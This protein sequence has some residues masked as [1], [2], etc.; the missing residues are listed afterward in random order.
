MKYVTVTISKFCLTRIQTYKYILL[1]AVLS[2]F[3][4][5]FLSLLTGKLNLLYPDFQLCLPEITTALIWGHV[6]SNFLKLHCC[7]LL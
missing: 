2:D 6:K 7:G 3:G 4:F 1:L 5:F